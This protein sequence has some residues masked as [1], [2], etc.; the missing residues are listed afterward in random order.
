M[1]G[2]REAK[3]DDVVKPKKRTTSSTTLVESAESST[4]TQENATKTATTP[5]KDTIH[6]SDSQS[7]I[8]DTRSPKSKTSKKREEPPPKRIATRRSGLEVDNIATKLSNLGKRGRKT[9]EKG[10][11]KMSLELRRLQDTKEFAGVDDKPVVYTYWANGKYVDPSAPQEPP[12][13]KAKVQDDSAYDVPEV[14]EEVVVE[15]PAPKKRCVKKWLDR[16]L[17]AGQDAPADIFKGLTAHEKKKLAQLPELAPN[18]EVNKTLPAPIYLGLRMLIEGR[19]FK[20]PFDVC[21]PLPPGQPKP[22]EWRKMTRSKSTK[23]VIPIMCLY[24]GH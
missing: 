2:K 9:L 12:A 5:V 24:M 8:R 11:A 6:A 22:D 3:G 16:G 21:N 14:E 7:S 19:D 4:S 15:E 13:K 18:A 17:Y 1:R 23:M 20:L 10:V